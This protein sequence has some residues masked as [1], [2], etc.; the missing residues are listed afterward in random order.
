MNFREEA[1]VHTKK[2]MGVIALIGVLCAGVPAG[3]SRAQA[4]GGDTA[5]S[6]VASSIPKGARISEHLYGLPG[7]HNVGLV[8]PGIYRGAQPEG[9]GYQTLKNM[10]IRTVIDLR[11]KSEKQ[12]VE[13]TGMKSLQFPM[14]QTVDVD[15]ETIRRVLAAMTDPANQP[16]FIHCAVGKDRTGVV[17][18]VYRMEVEG[19]D[20]RDAE[21]EMKAYGFHEF[22]G[23][24]KDFVRN[25]AVHGDGTGVPR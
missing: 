19:W 12:A 23:Q 10:G 8:A 18:A 9:K 11:H 24:F 1:M 21:E 2:A 4:P 20:E 5:G 13:A 14:A 22:L 25:Y 16:V 6:A 17:A 15:P 3:E 7:L